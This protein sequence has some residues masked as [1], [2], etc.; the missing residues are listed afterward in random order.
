MKLT[1]EYKRQLNLML[2]TSQA[3]TEA[4]AEDD[5]RRYQL[6][7]ILLK[8]QMEQGLKMVGEKSRIEG[9]VIKS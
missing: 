2:R 9:W 8:S 6:L 1:Q 7:T 3:I 4:I 5:R